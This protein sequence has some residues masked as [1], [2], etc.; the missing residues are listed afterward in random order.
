MNQKLKDQYDARARVLKALAHPSRLMIVDELS[1]Q[2]R[3][4]AELTEMVGSDMSTVSKHLATL[5]NVGIIR[6]EKRGSQVY[7]SL[8]VRC[9]PNF[10]GC[11]ESVLQANARQYLSLV[12]LKIK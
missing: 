8:V 9:I 12:E 7:Y 6:D 4:V 1:R 2:E 11:I 5:K 3:C 10:F